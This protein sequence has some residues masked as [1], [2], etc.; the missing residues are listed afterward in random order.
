MKN[1]VWKTKSIAKYYIGVLLEAEYAVARENAAGATWTLGGFLCRSSLGKVSQRVRESVE[2]RVRKFGAKTTLPAS[3]PIGA[4]NTIQRHNELWAR[5][6]VGAGG[7]IQN[8]NTY[9][10]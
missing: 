7:L 10:K 6:R 1:S 4:Q 8:S 2:A 3:G 9:I 5:P